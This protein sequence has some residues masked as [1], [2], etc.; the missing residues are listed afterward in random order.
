MIT[1]RKPKPAPTDT[2]HAAAQVLPVSRIADGGFQLKTGYWVG[3]VGVHGITWDLQ[4]AEERN[5][6][7]HRYRQWL[8]QQHEPW[9]IIAEASLPNFAE[10]IQAYRQRAQTW[11]SLETKEQGAET[12]AEMNWMFAEWLE[13]WSRPIGETVQ[14]WMAITATTYADSLR[15]GQALRASLATVHPA[16]MPWIPDA[17]E[18]IA[19][20][21]RWADRPNPWGDRPQKG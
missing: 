11:K 3:L 10:A 5:A 15:R 4:S 9:Q 13:H 20:W 17:H 2:R 14:F 19:A 21:A 12:L 1:P 18:I 7:L 6:M 8:V 16:L